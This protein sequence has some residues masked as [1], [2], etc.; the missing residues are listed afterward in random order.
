MLKLK[1][2]LIIFVFLQ[3]V[4]IA[5]D[6]KNP[7]GEK[8]AFYSNVG[9]N[10]SADD[11]ASNGDNRKSIDIASSDDKQIN[12][13]VDDSDLS[14]SPSASSPVASA[15]PVASV[16]PSPSVLAS[17]SPSPSNPFGQTDD[18][19]SNGLVGEVYELT[20]NIPKLP[21]DFESYPHKATILVK[22]L[23]VPNRSFSEG[24]PDVPELFEWFGIVFSGR[25]IIP[26]SGTYNFK[27]NSDD[28]SKLFIN[29][30]LVID[31][32]GQHSQAAKTGSIYLSQGVHKIVVQYFQGPRYHIALELFFKASG[33]STY[34]IIPK[35][36]FLRP[37]N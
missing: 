2:V 13:Q 6:E 28:G 27:L 5:C 14:P 11:I 4:L 25:I 10:S 26:L 16:Q 35:E 17:A 29:D 7:M 3:M 15:S 18:G 1:S 37:L 24:F 12:D 19:M 34:K 23:N 9:S 22:N 31:N 32:D 33:D 20:Y 8:T 36:A 30:Q 21:T